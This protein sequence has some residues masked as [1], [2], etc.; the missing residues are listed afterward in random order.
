LYNSLRR[1]E[2]YKRPVD[3]DDR[4]VPVESHRGTPADFL[5]RHERESAKAARRTRAQQATFANCLLQRA[6]DPRSIKLALD[7]LASKGGEAPGPNGLRASDLS[8]NERWEL[9]RALERAILS[10]T[11][12]PGPQR[13]I[14]IPKGGNR[15]YRTLQIQNVE[16]RAVQRAIVQVLQPFVD[17]GFLETT[18]GARPRK[19]RDHALALA[20]KLARQHGRWTWNVEDIQDAFNQV[21][22]NRLLDILRKRVPATE[23]LELIKVVIGNNRGR[24]LRQGGAL[25]PLCLNLYLDNV[26][27]RP[28]NRTHPQTPLIRVVDDLLMLSSDIDQAARAHDALK[29]MLK[30]AGMPLK[31]AK[32]A[33][34]DLT[35]GQ[36]IE[37]LGLDITRGPGGIEAHLTE[38]CWEKL[39]EALGVLHEEPDA[40]IR[41]IETIEAWIA[42]QGPCYS[43]EDLHEVYARIERVARLA[44]FEELPSRERV[45]DLWT[46]ARERWE[47]IRVSVDE[48][49]QEDLAA[50][51]CPFLAG[52]S[53]T[54]ATSGAP[55]VGAPHPSLKVR[56]DAPGILAREARDRVPATPR[57]ADQQ[58]GTQR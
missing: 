3:A 24:G 17:P 9:S 11:Y 23:F 14:Q 26:L 41:A 31:T 50:P 44:A 54:P 25:S 7:H 8:S 58:Q 45:H 19:G 2:G 1:R 42:Q 13:Q 56:I 35:T 38:R 28:W 27:D 5:R 34:R 51:P 10:G 18:L 29:T 20:E 36:A 30:P 40:P 16:D 21:P 15:G 47:Q 22:L 4:Q 37:W 55:T 57:K 32:S 39:Q 43:S 46:Q 48:R 6:A 12:R 33:T 52:N 49:Q 53:T